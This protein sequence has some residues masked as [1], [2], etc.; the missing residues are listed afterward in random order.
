MKEDRGEILL[1]IGRHQVQRKKMSVQSRRARTAHTEW[2]VREQYGG[3]S[4]LEVSL[5]TG[6][7]HQIRVHCAA[8]DHPILGDPVYGGKR[9]KSG[10]LLDSQGNAVKIPKRQMLHAWRLKF[11]HPA[12]GDEM[13]FESQMPED[14]AEVIRRLGGDAD[15][16]R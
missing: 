14:M 7:T 3:A 5:K 15:R 1:P 8:I 9:Q 13:M 4:L 6:R 16:N 10:V 12:T 2:R 11:V